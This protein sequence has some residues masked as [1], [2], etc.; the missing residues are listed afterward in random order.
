MLTISIVDDFC[1]FP[2]ALMRTLNHIDLNHL[3]TVSIPMVNLKFNL[4]SFS[5]TRSRYRWGKSQVATGSRKMSTLIPFQACLEILTSTG[6]DLQ[7]LAQSSECL[8]C[9]FFEIS[10]H[11]G[12]GSSFVVNATYETLIKVSVRTWLF[13]GLGLHI[14]VVGS[15]PIRVPGFF[16]SLSIPSALPEMQFSLKKIYA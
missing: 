9:D 15:N 14:E 8:G 2:H 11:F 4:I 5:K 16:F 6:S 7:F 13:F 12:N 3:A 1:E 10:D